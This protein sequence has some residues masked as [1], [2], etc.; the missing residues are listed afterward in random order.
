MIFYT[1]QSSQMRLRQNVWE[2][3]WIDQLLITQTGAVS[4]AV[5]NVFNVLWSDAVLAFSAPRA[6]SLEGILQGN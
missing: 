5:G 6:A 2:P 4:V 3:E 1:L